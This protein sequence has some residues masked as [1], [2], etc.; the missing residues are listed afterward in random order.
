M[1]LQVGK[2]EL[3]VLQVFLVTTHVILEEWHLVLKCLW[4]VHLVELGLLLHLLLVVI[5][6]LLLLV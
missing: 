5:E 3:R 4:V 1:I 6:L 2:V